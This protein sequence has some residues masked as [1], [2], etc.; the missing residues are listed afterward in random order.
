MSKSHEERIPGSEGL[1]ERDLI[2]RAIEGDVDAYEVLVER[3][4]QRIFNLI[5]RLVSRRENVEDLAQEVFIKAYRKIAG[6][7]FESSFYTWL[8]TIALNTCRNYYRRTEPMT[9]DLEIQERGGELAEKAALSDSPEEAVYRKQRAR[10]VKDALDR[11]PPEQKEALIL[12][13][14]EGMS[15]QEIADTIGVPIGTVRSRIFRARSNLKKLLPEDLS[16]P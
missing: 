6:F 10:L 12:C 4:K 14:L 13:D 2:R 3:Y 5:G 7:R 9:L 16:G 8:Y 15:Y 11:L 1:Q